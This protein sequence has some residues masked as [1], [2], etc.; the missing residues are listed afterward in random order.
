MARARYDSED[1]ARPLRRVMVGLLVLLLLVIFLVWR[2]DSPRVERFR[3]ALL[4][5]VVPDLSW[6]MV[7]VTK[8]SGM[9]ENFQSYARLYE[10]NQDC[11]LY[12]SPSPRDRG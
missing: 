9:V 5:R 12:T 10:Q 7:P 4:D 1:F 6:A 2:I 8:A 11:L 3:T